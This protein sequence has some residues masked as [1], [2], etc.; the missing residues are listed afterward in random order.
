MEKS[1]GWRFE[2]RRR[3]KVSVGGVVGVE[4]EGRVRLREKL[5]CRRGV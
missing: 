2:G 1:G 3:E 5:L 4:G